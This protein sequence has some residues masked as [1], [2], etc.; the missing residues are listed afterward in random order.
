[1]RNVFESLASLLRKANLSEPITKNYLICLENQLQQMGWMRQRHFLDRFASKH[2]FNNASRKIV[3]HSGCYRDIGYT[4]DWTTTLHFERSLPVFFLMS[5][6]RWITMAGRCEP[7]GQLHL[8]FKE[9]EDMW[10]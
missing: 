10:L 9:H 2:V 8:W 5:M 4:F 6:R 3:V 1:M 7:K